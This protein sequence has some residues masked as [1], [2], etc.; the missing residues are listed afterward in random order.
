MGTAESVFSDFFFSLANVNAIQILDIVLVALVFFLTLNLLRR[1]RATVLFRGALVLLAIFF[2]VTVFLPLPT[3]D[4]IL[5]LLLIATLIATPIIFQPELRQLLE[6][7]GRR[8]GSFGLRRQ[9]TETALRPI[10]NT[11]ENLSGRGIGGLIVLEGS[12]DLTEIMQTGVPVGSNVSTEL[13]QTIFYDG[14]PLHDG[15]VMIRGDRIVAAGCV[16]PVSNR[17]LYSNQRRLG[18]RHRA[19]VGLTETSDA[20]VVVVSEETGDISVARNG[21]LQSDVDKTTLREQMHNFYQRGEQAGESN[22]SRQIWTQ[23]TQWVR[24]GLHLPSREDLLPTLTLMVVATLLALAT[25]AFVIQ[26]TNP[27]R[28]VR[29]EDIPLQIVGM[30]PN[31]VLRT[32]PTERVSAVVK[33]PNATIDSLGTGSFQAQISLEGLAPGLHRVPVSIESSARPVQIVSVNPANADIQLAEVVTRTVEVQ[34][35]ASGPQLPSP[36]LELRDTPI[37]T[38]TQVVVSGAAALVEMIDHAVVDVPDIEAAGTVRRLQPVLLVD[39]DGEVVRDVEAQPEQV[40]LGFTVVQRANARDVA[41]RVVTDGAVP[42]GYRLSRL[43]AAP[44]AVTLLGGEAQLAEV[45]NVIPT[46]PVDLSQAVEDITIQIPLNLPP[47]VEAVDEQGETV[48]TALVTVEV[49]ERTDNRVVTR[50]VEIDGAAGL[51]VE[52]S[53]QTVDL[54][55]S[56]PVPLLEE[57]EAEPRLLRVVINA[58]EL[59]DLDPGETIS[60]APTII[61]PDNVRVRLSTEQI[62]VTAP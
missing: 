62:Q 9:A 58:S 25:W 30:P 4:Y 55:L 28:E 48:R 20:L 54:L 21:R 1:S 29:V 13:L 23:F 6:E 53:P 26:E 40:Q 8:V 46:L 27:I 15:A 16:L 57:I 11:A 31:T 42:E 12:D 49:D 22:V 19:A 61:A 43:L 56:G 37:V 2:M 3:F 7:L 44:A 33:A 52:I 36:A 50:Q 35:D 18:T 32:E 39:R 41:V 51:S 45:G 10:S 14:T 38:P 17:Q 34:I 24:G 60:V 5:E 47:G 59:S